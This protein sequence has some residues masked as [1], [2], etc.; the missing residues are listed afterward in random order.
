MSYS[1]TRIKTT[2]SNEAHKTWIDKQTICVIKYY[3]VIKR[4]K[5]YENHEN[6]I[7]FIS[8]FKTM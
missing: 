6:F 4:K 1:K 2:V 5:I 8:L 3:S 7:T